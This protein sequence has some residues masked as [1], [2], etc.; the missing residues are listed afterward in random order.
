MTYDQKNRID[1]MDYATMLELWRYS[2]PGDALFQGDT[3]KYFAQRMAA[4]RALLNEGEHSQVS[5]MVDEN[6]CRSVS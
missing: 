2:P 6:N 3:G 4:L 1:G 5:R